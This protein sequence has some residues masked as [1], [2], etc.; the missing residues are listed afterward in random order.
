MRSHVVVLLCSVFSFLSLLL[1]G[2]R[3][4][5]HR[6]P[7]TEILAKA[8]KSEPFGHVWEM[9]NLEGKSHLSSA[10]G[11][12]HSADIG[13]TPGVPAPEQALGTEK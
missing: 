2:S 4:Q 3:E 1:G 5:A 10:P 13:G 11:P 12:I 7:G 8:L 6:P 9:G